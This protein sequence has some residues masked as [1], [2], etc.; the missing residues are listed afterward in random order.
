MIK[1]S[2]SA[3]RTKKKKDKY[4]LLGLCTDCGKPVE[5]GYR[6]CRKCISGDRKTCRS[7]YRKNRERKLLYAR[8]RKKWLKENGMCANCGN[9]LDEDVD[10]GKATCQNCRERLYSDTDLTRGK[11]WKLLKSKSR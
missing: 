4:R 5:P 8:K 10:Y 11:Q 7:W 9:E 3:M 1:A 6:M 2:D